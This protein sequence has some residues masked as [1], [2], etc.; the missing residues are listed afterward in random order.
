M[1]MRFRSLLLLPLLAAAVRGSPV[2][3]DPT[4]SSVEIAVKATVGS[5]VARLGNF[6][7]TIT[8][9]TGKGAMPTATF[10]FAFASI[11]TGNEQRDRDMNDWQQTDRFPTAAFTLASLETTAPGVVVAH[12]RLLLHGIERPLSFPVSL[13][14][15]GTSVTV[16]GDLV[17]DTREFG[18]P[19]IRKFVVLKVDPVVRVHFRLQGSRSGT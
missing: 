19:V 14:I 16:T 13:E 5:F 15:A 10:R 8:I 7:A 11:K 17:V 6:D 2:A 12:G 4:R 18:L 9:P 3:V 1:R